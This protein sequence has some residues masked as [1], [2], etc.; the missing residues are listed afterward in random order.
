MRA[1]T[2]MLSKIHGDE[3][4]ALDIDRDRAVRYSDL[5]RARARLHAWCRVLDTVAEMRSALDQRIWRED[6][7]D[8]LLDA[9]IQ[10]WGELARAL[11]D[12][13]K[14]RGAA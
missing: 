1:M 12:F 14:V 5:V 7:E 3:V 8:A 10:R 4:V 2:A 11:A 9:D 13:L 6:P